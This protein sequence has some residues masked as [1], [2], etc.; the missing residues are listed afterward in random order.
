MSAAVTSSNEKGNDRI[1]TELGYSR[2]TSG[3]EAHPCSFV[4]VSGTGREKG[5]STFSPGLQLGR[6]PIPPYVLT[7]ATD[8][9]CVLVTLL[10]LRVCMVE[11]RKC[12]PNGQ[13]LPQSVTTLEEKLRNKM[14]YWH[15]CSC[16]GKDLKS[17]SSQMVVL[18]DRSSTSV[19]ILAEV[20]LYLCIYTCIRIY[21]YIYVYVQLYCNIIFFFC[22][23]LPYLE[24]Q[25]S[26]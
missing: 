9:A 12:Y 17:P 11:Y 7:V 1:W 14:K 2:A 20:C 18:F 3:A 23:V 19:V 15:F 22:T 13:A 8:D 10:T 21:K 16:S 25:R 4:C 5:Q 26:N 24:K 6:L